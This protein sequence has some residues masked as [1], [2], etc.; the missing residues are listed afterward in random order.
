VID[1]PLLNSIAGQ[2]AA[3][4]AYNPG[5]VNTDGAT[6]YLDRAGDISGAV[7]SKFVLFSCWFRQQTDSSNL[8]LLG[9]NGTGVAFRFQKNSSNNLVITWDQGGSFDDG[10]K[11]TL[12]DTILAADGWHHWAFSCDMADTGKRH[13]YLDGVSKSPTW[14]T[15]VNAT[16]DYTRGC[17]A[18]A[19]DDNAGDSW[20]GDAAE[21]YF[22]SEYLD[23]SVAANLEKFIKNGYPVEITNGGDDITG[24]EPLLFFSGDSTAFVTNQ[25]S[26]GAFSE[27][28]T[29]GDASGIIKIGA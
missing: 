7:D 5:G 20:D 21:L 17:N 4:A 28:G 10:L 15:Y 2:G 22:T 14:T 6:T 3:L 12:S 27:V 16:L 1:M 24:T 26:G 29:L 8:H 13:F 19:V 25:G 9:D 23:L 18:L 11:V